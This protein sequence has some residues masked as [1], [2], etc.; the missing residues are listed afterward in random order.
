MTSLKT[1][2]EYRPP[3]LLILMAEGAPGNPGMQVLKAVMSLKGPVPQAL[4]AATRNLY[5]FPGCSSW[6]LISGLPYTKYTEC[7]TIATDRLLAPHIRQGGGRVFGDLISCHSKC[8]ALDDV[9]IVPRFFNVLRL[10]GSRDY[11]LLDLKE[12]AIS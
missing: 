8:C 4:I 9:N 11:V 3:T 10:R 1:I 6:R 7:Q 12:V 2:V 5:A